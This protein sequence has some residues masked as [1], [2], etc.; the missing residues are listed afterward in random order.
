M[1][2]LVDQLDRG[3]SVVVAES[4]LGLLQG[5]LNSVGG[6]PASCAISPN[7]AEDGECQTGG[8]HAVDPTRYRMLHEPILQATGAAFGGTLYIDASRAVFLRERPY[9]QT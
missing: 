5:F 4:E 9:Y 6:L 2:S 1:F 8:E 3:G 7:R